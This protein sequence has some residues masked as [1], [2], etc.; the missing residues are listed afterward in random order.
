MLNAHFVTGDGRGNENI[1]LTTVHSI[2]HSEHNRLVD[3][4]KATICIGDLA[5]INQWP[6]G[7]SSPG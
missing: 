2:F 7:S 3:A 1:A 5:F 6:R 4:N